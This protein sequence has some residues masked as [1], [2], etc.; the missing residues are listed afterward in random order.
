MRTLFAHALPFLIRI[1]RLLLS[2]LPQKGIFH[3]FLL[4]E[5]LGR[6]LALKNRLC[7][8]SALTAGMYHVDGYPLGGFIDAGS[9]L[10]I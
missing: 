7:R 4:S 9:S 10:D 5:P 8:R 6:M 1:N 3:L 2:T